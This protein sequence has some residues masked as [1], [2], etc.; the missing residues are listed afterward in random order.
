ME[1]LK[2]IYTITRMHPSPFVCE[3]CK[4]FKIKLMKTISFEA[5]NNELTCAVLWRN[6]PEKK[7]WLKLVDE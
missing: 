6:V 5:C 3:N 4:H 7:I 1:S 2:H